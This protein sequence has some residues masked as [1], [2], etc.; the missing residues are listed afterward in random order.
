VRPVSKR[1]PRAKMPTLE[2]TSSPVKSILK[3]KEKQKISIELKKK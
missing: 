2:I 1:K 3:M